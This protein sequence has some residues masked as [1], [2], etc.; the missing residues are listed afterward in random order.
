MRQVDKTRLLF[1]ALTV[2]EFVR[3]VGVRAAPNGDATLIVADGMR[4]R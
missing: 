3:D 1:Q 4:A 2:I